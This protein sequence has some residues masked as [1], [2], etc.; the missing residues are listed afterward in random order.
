MLYDISYKNLFGLKPLCIRF[1]EVDGFIRVYDGIRCLALF[2]PEKSDAVYNTISYLVSQKSG[3]TYVFSHN[4][5][6]IK[7][8]FYDSLPPE[9]ILTLLNV[10]IPITPVL[11]KDKID[12]IAIYF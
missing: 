5:A 11:N 10:I 8:D 7:I 4:Y 6:K 3:V 9:K 12:I 1:D 2:A